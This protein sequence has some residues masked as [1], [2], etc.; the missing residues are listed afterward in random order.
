[1]TGFP[2]LLQRRVE[3]RAGILSQA[4]VCS[5]S[6]QVDRRD[7]V[8]YRGLSY[9][10]RG[11]FNAL[12]ATT[13]A[14]MSLTTRVSSLVLCLLATGAPVFT[15]GPRTLTAQAVAEAASSKTWLGRRQALEDYL[16]TADVI[17]MEDIGL[18]V[19]HFRAGRTRCSS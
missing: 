5:V 13:E 12:L 16:R 10:T 3:H 11:V 9:R 2:A 15:S 14:Q 6:R 7:A 1:V 18:G 17:K 4:I 19:N 8:E